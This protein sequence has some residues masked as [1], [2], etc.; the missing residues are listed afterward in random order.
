M[1]RNNKQ[2]PPRSNTS[3]KNSKD[4]T[5]R[6][7]F[8]KKIN[9]FILWLAATGLLAFLGNYI[10]DF[11][12]G[13]VQVKYVKSSGRNYEFNLTNKSSTDQV[14]EQFRIVPDLTQK[15]IYR[16]TKD[17]TGV[18][19]KNGVSIPGGNTSSMEGA[20]KQVISS[21]ADS[22]IKISRIWAD[23]FPANTSN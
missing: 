22:L 13:D 2:R 23:F 7:P 20:N 15:V 10:F 17:V 11:L 16:I 1:A 4:K 21:Q 14:I 6:I 3:K 8:H 5:V 19:T 18:F 9:G 12:T